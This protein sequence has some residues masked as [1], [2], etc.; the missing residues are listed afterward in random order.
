MKNSRHPSS[1]SYINNKQFLGERR[2]GVGVGAAN[3]KLC[4][5]TSLMLLL[6]DIHWDTVGPFSATPAQV[7]HD[8]GINPSAKC[9]QETQPFTKL[10][11]CGIISLICHQLPSCSG[12]LWKGLVTHGYLSKDQQNQSV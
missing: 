2:L 8:P 12:L 9:L 3:C 11:L 4:R 1:Q 7:I 5:E 10:D 6:S